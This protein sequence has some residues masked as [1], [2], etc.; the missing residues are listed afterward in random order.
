VSVHAEIQERHPAE[1]KQLPAAWQRRLG[2]HV[3]QALAA[4]VDRARRLAWPVVIASV[5]AAL[6]GGIYTAGHLRMNTNI[7][8]LLS[9]DV[10]YRKTL[11]T[12]EE[13]FPQLG[14]N[15]AVVVESES[16]ERAE[17]A[18]T[19]LAAKLEA[20]K[21]QFSDVF[22][23]A[24]DAFFRREGL[25]FLKTADLEQLAKRVK[26]A[27]PILIGFAT[28]RSLR[29]F[30]DVL[31]D[32]LDGAKSGK[33]DPALLVHPLN[34]VGD[35]VEAELN[36]KS[37]AL[38]WRD[39]LNETP[40]GTADKR[41]VIQLKPYLDRS[42]LSP[43]AAAI[44][45]I[46]DTAVELGLVPSQG[47]R[48]RI[49]GSPALDEDDLK[50]VRDGVGLASAVSF[51]LVSIIVFL[52]LRSPRLVFATIATLVL[53]LVWTATFATLAVGYL[54]MISVAFAVLF[55]GL[56]VDFSIQFGLRYK[57]SIDRGRP[58]EG[59]LKEAASGTG[60]AVTL[61]AVSAAIGFLAFVP[62]DYIGL[63][64]LG[65]IAGGGMFLG[66]FATL[67]LLP[68]ILALLPLRADPRMAEKRNLTAAAGWLEGHARAVCLGALAL[69]IAALGAFPW[70]RFDIDPID[71]KSPNTESV[72]VYRD[73]TKDS[74]VSPY[75]AS[76]LTPNLAAADALA[77]RLGKLP[78]VAS[79]VTLSKFLPEDQEAKLPV[80]ERISA[81][82]T[83]ILKHQQRAAP[84]DERRRSAVKEGS[85][86]LLAFA[87][88]PSAGAAAAPAKRLAGLLAR[89]EDGPGKE[90]AAYGRLEKD[91]VSSISSKLDS[92]GELLQPEPVTIASLPDSIRAR[93]LAADGR[94]RVQ[95]FPAETLNNEAA[96]RRF[97]NA[98]RTLAPNATDSPVA[99]LE[100][101]RMVVGA[102]VEAGIIALAAI[103]LLLV[104]VLASVVDALLVLLPLMLAAVLTV[105]TV[106]VTGHAFNFA[107]IIALPLLFSLGVA[108]G[109]YYV[110]RHRETPGLV[111][112]MHTSTP[113]AIL[114]SALV[115]MVSFST[116]MLSSHRG[117]ASMG[118]LLGV[119]LALAVL[120]T[121]VVLPALLTWRERRR[122]PSS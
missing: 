56:A 15:L 16:A 113:R 95:V 38:S 27:Q 45:T 6:G 114:F 111:D 37:A 43:A 67:T 96:L 110:L 50:T 2:P 32:V 65:I 90:L 79:T 36:G 103:G 29:G 112:L 101:G 119:S 70:A 26:D 61:A 12:F 105:A 9:S 121:L 25:L 59:A 72:Q 86:T 20:N 63:S 100:G 48:V 7:D 99:L 62:T 13:A 4:W 53:S 18:A 92:L 40:A 120:C 68:A 118:F 51:V 102:F 44:K 31:S 82:V 88:S 1:G 107:N 23:P 85:E 117:T 75:A 46:R 52:G 5:L 47:V 94:A 77:A 81:I 58:L 42:S 55:I 76:I 78:E 49:T 64:Q 98:V 66:L 33:L 21:Q 30:F 57:E 8:A 11:K 17:S 41:Q 116:L 73:M 19:A 106:V 87:S 14:D 109:I 24:G 74:R 93:Y 60:M 89:F 115:T 80:I 84:S 69:G 97:V 22:Y 3:A 108:F 10:P 28:D 104:V 83:P 35:S 39:L 34:A 54:N 71:L 91:L 122:T